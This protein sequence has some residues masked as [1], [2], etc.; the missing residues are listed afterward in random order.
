VAAKGCE[1]MQTSSE[2]TLRRQHFRNLR[3]DFF[4]CVYMNERVIYVRISNCIVQ[5]HVSQE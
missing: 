4:V 2:K 3:L 5:A 1:R